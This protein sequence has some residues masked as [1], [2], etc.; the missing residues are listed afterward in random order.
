M[1]KQSSSRKSFLYSFL[2]NLEHTK[3][4]RR[5]T[6]DRHEKGQARRNREQQRAKGKKRWTEGN[7]SLMSG[8]GCMAQLL[9]LIWFV[10][11]CDR[12]IKY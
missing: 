11:F 4:A 8:D 5:S 10:S 9:I 7:Q 1:L 12:S 6:K 3:N 2:F